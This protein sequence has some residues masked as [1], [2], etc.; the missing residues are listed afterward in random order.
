MDRIAVLDDCTKTANVIGYVSSEEDAADTF[1]AYM[2]ERMDA[3]DF[4]TLR[5]PTFVYR[6]ETS[7]ASPAFEPMFQ[8]SPKE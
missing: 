2:Q 8:Y 4:A 1:M 5:R 3:D 7:V 6:A